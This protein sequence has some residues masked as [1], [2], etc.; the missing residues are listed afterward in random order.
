MKLDDFHIR[1]YQ[2]QDETDIIDLWNRCD[3]LV[4]WNN[5]K[6]DIERKLKVNPE[7][8]LVGLIGGKVVATV[9][10]GYEGRRGWIN[11]L[12][13]SPDHQRSGLGRRIMEDAE[14]KL[15]ALGCPKV[16]LQIR[17]GNLAVIK[18]YESIGYSIEDVVSMGK[19]LKADPKYSP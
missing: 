11:Y 19:R 15:R 9:M 17:T 3:L 12:A 13:V 7:L 6:M 1:P 14:A 16:N 8:F 10:G 4:P 2:R 5:P 18:F